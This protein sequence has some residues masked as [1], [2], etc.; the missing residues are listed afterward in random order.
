MT[1]AEMKL[2]KLAWLVGVFSSLA[3]VPLSVACQEP[4][5]LEITERTDVRHMFTGTAKSHGLKITNLTG[6]PITIER[7]I[8]IERRV[9]SRWVHETAVQAV[10]RCE[11]FDVHYPWKA[12]IRIDPHATLDVVAWDGFS[13]GGQCPAACMQNT[14]VASGILRFV[15][16]FQDG[17]RILS[18]EFSI[19]AHSKSWKDEPAHQADRKLCTLTANKM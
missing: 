12:P 4:L 19:S 16:V 2:L 14:K 5:R 7:G 13:C 1:G 8:L 15:V 18:P 10:D 17:K 6:T 3:L 11:N 9:S